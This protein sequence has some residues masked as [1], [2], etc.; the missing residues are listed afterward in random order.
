[1]TRRIKLPQI[2]NVGPGNRAT[3]NIPLGLTYNKIYIECTGNLDR[4]FMSNLVF[5]INTAEKQRW[6]T[7]LQMQAYNSYR[8][9]ASDSKFVTFNFIEKDAKEEASMFIGA[10]ALTAG[11]GVQSASIEFDLG[12]YTASALTSIRAYAE[13]DVPSDNRLIVRTRYQQKTL[14]GAVEEQIVLPSGLNGE[15]V[16]RILIYGTLASIDFARIRR[17]GADEFESLTV[18]QNEFSQKEYAKVPQA[19]CMIIDFQEHNLAGHTL[20]TAM[21]KGADGKAYP[22]QNLDFRLQT[23][24][25]GTFDIYV[26]SLV[27]ND[28]P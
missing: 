21:V 18:L 20:N 11:A 10:Y 24:A 28:R 16:K 15:Q 8:G 7:A 17:D 3:I 5:K 22:I 19:G 1:M 14:A 6:K 4:T 12:A 9:G 13:V 23:N 2:Q 27:L 25:A 26:E